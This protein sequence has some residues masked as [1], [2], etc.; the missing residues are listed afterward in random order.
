MEEAL[1]NINYLIREK[2]WGSAKNYCEKVNFD[3]KLFSILFCRN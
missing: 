3:L 2:L 1:I